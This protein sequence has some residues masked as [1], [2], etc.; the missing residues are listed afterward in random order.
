[1][2]SVV[3][4]GAANTLR[5]HQGRIYADNTD[6]V[7]LVRDIMVNAQ[8]A[9]PGKSALILGAGGGGAGVLGPLIAAG[10]S[11]ITVANRTLAKAQSLCQ[12]HTAA[13]QAQTCQLQACALTEVSGSYDLVINAT[14]TSLTG[15]AVPV[16]G[17]ALKP[18]ALAY[19]LMYGPNAQT[20]LDWASAHGAS[21]RDG[22]G[23]L[24]EQAA[25]AFFIWRG[26]RPPAA[27]VLTELRASL[28]AA[29]H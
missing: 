28:T 21:G 23:M 3:L 13:S 19:D 24:V 17:Q 18:G 11:H 15:G 27:Q 14:V 16:S 1:M 4:A 8:F 10:L 12:S 25:E 7:G 20:F 29:A 22:L 5:F 2:A 26:V 6:G 9:L